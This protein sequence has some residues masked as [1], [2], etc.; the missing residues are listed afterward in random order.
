M[1][2]AGQII[3]PSNVKQRRR[4]EKSKPK[5]KAMVHRTSGSSDFF[6]AFRDKPYA[7]RYGEIHTATTFD[8]F[9]ASLIFVFCAFGFSFLILLPGYMLKEVGDILMPKV[10]R[11]Y[12]SS[13]GDSCSHSFYVC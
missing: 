6:G 9:D 4:S 3:N 10:F 2:R 8:T 13:S 7:T 1:L 5:T 11:E 12:K